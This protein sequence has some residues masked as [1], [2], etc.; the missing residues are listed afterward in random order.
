[1]RVPSLANLSV[2]IKTRCEFPLQSAREGA[3]DWPTGL[4]KEGS[5]RAQSVPRDGTCFFHSIAYLLPYPSIPGTEQGRLSKARLTGVQLRAM[6]MDYIDENWKWFGQENQIDRATFPKQSNESLK[7]FVQRYTNAYRGSL[8]AGDVEQRAV[9]E[10]LNA[11]IVIVQI[12]GFNRKGK[13]MEHSRFARV[14]QST[15]PCKREFVNDEKLGDFDV[16]IEEEEE[17][18]YFMNPDRVQYVPLTVE[19]ARK[20][21]TYVLVWHRPQTVDPNNPAKL[22][23]GAP[24]YSPIQPRADADKSYESAAPETLAMST[25]H[26]NEE[27]QR[28]WLQYQ[29]DLQAQ[30]CVRDVKED[31]EKTL[32]SCE[33]CQKEVEVELDPALQRA[34]MMSVIEE[35]QKELKKRQAL[36]AEQETRRLRGKV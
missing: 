5:L 29:A 7:Q 1:M 2:N 30:T 14:H 35:N 4:G 23:R 33:S 26:E 19:E 24:H 3:Y 34:I 9:A 31:Y 17:K 22:I 12:D 32:K 16:R 36:E 28:L 6:T 21:P 25:Q 8:W 11:H 20:I 15:W 10:M 18:R 13:P 27:M